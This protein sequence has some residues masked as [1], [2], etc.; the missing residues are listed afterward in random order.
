LY[1]L[2]QIFLKIG[3]VQIN[4]KCEENIKKQDISIFTEMENR[5]ITLR[6]FI[7]ITHLF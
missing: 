3:R 1:Y 4:N 5:K 2:A 7:P 6:E